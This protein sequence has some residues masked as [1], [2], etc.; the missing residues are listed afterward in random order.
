MRPYYDADGVTLYLGDCQEAR[1]VV[2]DMVLTDIPYGEVNRRSAG[3]RNL[4]KGL[5][6]IVTVPLDVVV[7]VAARTTALSHYIWCGTEQVSE[8]RRDFV[9]RG[10]T[11]RLG[12]WDKTNPS[13]H[14]G[15]HLWL[16]GLETCV[17][18]RKSKAYFSE[19]CKSPVWRGPSKRGTGHPTEKPL[20]LFRRLIEAS[21]APGGVVFDG[22]AGSGTT[23]VAAR[24]CGRRAI[25]I[26]IEE[27]YCEIA[28]KRLSQG[29]LGVEE[30]AW[31]TPQRQ[32]V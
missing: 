19:H 14:N 12:V 31:V 10:F 25:G 32:S 15:Q 17:F 29:V 11:T 23:L 7:E 1:G 21:C 3:L 27:R 9:A 26:E 28:A 22:F 2:A 5:A 24:A 30:A 8:L 4:D 13:P 6:D 18:A 20:W 16:S